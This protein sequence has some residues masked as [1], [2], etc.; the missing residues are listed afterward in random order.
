[1][2]AAAKIYFLTAKSL[3]L[4]D[5]KKLFQRNFSYFVIREPFF[6]FEEP[7]PPS[8]VYLW[9]LVFSISIYPIFDGFVRIKFSQE[10]VIVF[11]YAE[12]MFFVNPRKFLP[13]KS[14]QM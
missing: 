9:L 7:K 13:R 5:R 4:V 2:F 1:M 11:L 6:D 8:L 3:N 12:K 10:A 14:L